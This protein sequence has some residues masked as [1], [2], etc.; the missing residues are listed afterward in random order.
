MTAASFDLVLLL[1]FFVYG[2]A[3]FS[4]GMTLAIESGRFQ[5][6]ADAQ[7]L[8]PLAIFGLI[9]GIHEW[10]EAYL[11][12]AEAFGTVL[13]G[14][15]PWL[16]LF[17]LAVSFI[18]LLIFVI[19][20]FRLRPH[21]YS[22]GGY[23]LLLTLGGYVLIILV[24]AFNAIRS[25][26]I[27]WF[28]LLNVLARYLLAFPGAILAAMAL[29][30][31]AVGSTGEER[32]HLIT[33]LTVAAIG[34]LIYGLAQ[35]FVPYA[36]M[37]PARYINVTFFRNW[38]GFPIQVVRAAMAVMITMGLVRATQLAERERQR[39]AAAAQK[40]HLEAL[41]QRDNLRHE[42]LFHTVQAQEEERSRIAREL[43]DETAQVLT[44][45][46]LDLATLRKSTSEHPKTI[47]LVDRLLLLSKQMAQGIYRLVHDLRPAQLDDLGLIPA[48]QYLKD[49]HAS[50]GL[51]V[52]MEVQGHSRRMDAIIETVLFRVIQEALNNV[53]RHAQTRNAHIVVNFRPQEI[54]IKV[55]DS[56]IGFDPEKPLTPPHGWGLAGMRERVELI[57]GQLR[58]DSGSD[59]GTTVEVI[60]PN[61]EAIIKRGL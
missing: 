32:P 41:E 11:M 38:S 12:Q 53:H 14:W 16:R 54:S 24:S 27:S 20:A 31:Q 4:L 42:L 8:R 18:F 17:L 30:L 51:D 23:L 28:D 1:V 43:H 34:F 46:S 26:D 47:Q 19:Q 6:L 9:H 13:P 35:L 56:G 58:I 55:I 60:V 5:A 15:L 59:R 44:A 36:D 7:V 50:Q 2:L 39:L 40:T 45:F 48:I 25:A 61:Q 52:S 49:S 10:L 33:H 22:R 21:K 57:N 29:R 37:F 3:F